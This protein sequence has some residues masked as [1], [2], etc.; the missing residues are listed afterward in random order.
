M[1][2]EPAEKDSKEARTKI[3]REVFDRP[4]GDIINENKK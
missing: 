4:F 2:E 1:N 3:V